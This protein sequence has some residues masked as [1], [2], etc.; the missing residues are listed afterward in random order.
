MQHIGNTSTLMVTMGTDHTPDEVE[1]ILIKH[2]SV[3]VD[4]HLDIALHWRQTWSLDKGMFGCVTIIAWDMAINDGQ[5]VIKD[6]ICMVS[7]ERILNF[8]CPYI[9]FLDKLIVLKAF[10]AI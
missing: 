1:V 3:I 2:W 10:L 6:L 4:G 7:T 5:I 9:P 8:N